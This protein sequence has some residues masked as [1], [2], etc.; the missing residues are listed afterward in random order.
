MFSRRMVSASDKFS[1]ESWM[2]TFD[3][4]FFKP[5]HLFKRNLIKHTPASKQ[6]RAGSTSYF[7]QKTLRTTMVKK[8]NYKNP[9]GCTQ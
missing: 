5:V 3:K 1:L 9:L 7:D 4:W 2:L 6:K 8:L